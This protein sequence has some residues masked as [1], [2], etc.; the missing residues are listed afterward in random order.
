M[1]SKADETLVIVETLICPLQIYYSSYLYNLRQIFI[2]LTLVRVR[3]RAIVLRRDLVNFMFDIF[4][5]SN[6]FF[7]TAFQNVGGSNL[8]QASGN[9]P[10]NANNYGAASAA[11]QEV[12]AAS[13]RQMGQPTCGNAMGPYAIEDDFTGKHAAH[14]MMTA[15][16]MYAGNR[17]G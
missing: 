16:S 5:L 15:K 17:T 2:R 4:S 13:Q 11:A 1:R 9:L 10:Q 7:F 6:N 12:L 3:T 8:E 14:S